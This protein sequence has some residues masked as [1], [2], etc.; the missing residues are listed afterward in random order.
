MP[1]LARAQGK[2]G[3]ARAACIAV[4]AERGCW[5]LAGD[6]SGVLERAAGEAIPP[7]RDD[8]ASD[9]LALRNA[10]V[11][12]PRGPSSQ[13]CSRCCDPYLPM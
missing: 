4:D 6:G 10:Q 9:T 13:T 5:A 7:F 8:K 3:E 12:V 2:K 1:P 11:G